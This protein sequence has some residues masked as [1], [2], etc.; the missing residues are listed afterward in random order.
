M[1]YSG[2]ARLISV[3]FMFIA[4]ETGSVWWM[5]AFLI[6]INLSA[7]FYFPALQATLPLVVEKKIYCSL[8]EYIQMFLP[9]PAFLVQPLLGFS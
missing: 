6:A 7:A 5:I 3:A 9:Y 1:L 2:V 4:I 8:T